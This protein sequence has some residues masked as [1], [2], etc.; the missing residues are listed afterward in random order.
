MPRTFIISS[1]ARLRWSWEQWGHQVSFPLFN[2]KWR[3][4]YK[5]MFIFCKIC[6]ANAK[7]LHNIKQS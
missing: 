6:N 3:I 2:N 4:G 1:R 7:D 5:K